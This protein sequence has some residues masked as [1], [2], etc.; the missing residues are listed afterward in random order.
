MTI[1]LGLIKRIGIFLLLPLFLNISLSLIIDEHKSSTWHTVLEIQ[2]GKKRSLNR[3]I[4]VY[5]EQ[6]WTV[7]VSIGFLFFH[8]FFFFCSFGFC[9]A[10]SAYFLCYFRLSV[11]IPFVLWIQLSLSL[12]NI[13]MEIKNIHDVIKEKAIFIQLLASNL[14]LKDSE[15]I[16]TKL[17]FICIHIEYTA[18]NI[19]GNRRLFGAWSLFICSTQFH[20]FPAPTNDQGTT[21]PNEMP[22]IQ[23]LVIKRTRSIWATKFIVVMKFV[24]AV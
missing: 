8:S 17:M 20:S 19:N 21:K 15:I 12:S 22:S 11:L 2:R 1:K 9:V 5:M 10:R 23:V 24:R 14:A 4:Y 3:R 7:D 16:W 6:Q 13:K 18:L